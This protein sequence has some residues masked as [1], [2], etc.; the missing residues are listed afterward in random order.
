MRRCAVALAA[1]MAVAISAPSVASA[2]TWAESGDAGSLL[3]DAQEPVGSGT[4]DAITGA[5]STARPNADEDVYKMCLTGESFSATT[6]TSVPDPMLLL[7]DP[8]GV[9]DCA[10]RRAALS[11]AGER[12]A[13]RKR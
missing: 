10:K 3:A 12:G 8:D 5:I 7:L 9:L 6:S 2:D 1:V 11:A 4:L 13:G